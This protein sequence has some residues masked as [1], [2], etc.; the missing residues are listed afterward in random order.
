[1]R[2]GV[3]NEK[4]VNGQPSFIRKCPRI[5]PSADTIEEGAITEPVD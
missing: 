2:D 5:K 3:L 1:M 4:Q